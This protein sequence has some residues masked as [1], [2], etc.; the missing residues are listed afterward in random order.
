[1][2]QTA[3]VFAALSILIFASCSANQ[4][5]LIESDGSGEA[6]IEIVV[7][8]FFARYLADISAGF[9]DADAPLFDVPGIE[10]AFAEYPDIHLNEIE[11]RGEYGLA[12][13]LEFDAIDRF[14]RARDD[15]VSEILS[16]DT[17]GSRRLIRAR[18]DRTSVER[19]LEFARID[20]SITEILLPP[21]GDMGAGEYGE[22][23]SWALEEY[24]D[25]SVLTETLTRS[26]IR[27]VVRVNGEIRSVTGGRTGDAIEGGNAPTGG[28]GGASAVFSMP[29]LRLLTTGTPVEYSVLFEPE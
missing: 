2:R 13:R 29:L 11:L 25:S 15:V 24:E 4:D 16:F 6:E 18:L 7:E 17:D 12:L 27:T 20:P 23:L 5:F 8:P 14:L 28:R 26:R 21:A 9:G 22:Y 1:M 19:A 3:A 10:A